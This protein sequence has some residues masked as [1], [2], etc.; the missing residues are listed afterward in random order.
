M[1]VFF[2]ASSSSKTAPHSIP[3]IRYFPYRKW[4]SLPMGMMW[5]PVFLCF[6]Q[7]FGI[8]SVVIKSVSEP[9]HKLKP[10]GHDAH[11]SNPASPGSIVHSSINHY[12]ES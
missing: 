1:I 6:S 7:I 9:F 10:L 12:G 3:P 4:V 8:F 11:L 5:M 2:M